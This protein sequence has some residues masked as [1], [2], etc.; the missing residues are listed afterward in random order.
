M[1]ISDILSG[2][3]KWCVNRYRKGCGL[4]FYRFPTDPERR[5]RWVAA[6]AR[7]NWTPNEYSRLCSAHFVTGTKSDDPLSPD[8]VPTLFSHVE[9][10]IKRKAERDLMSMLC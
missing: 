10:P 2:K 3:N 1:T 4:S 7:K 9:S 5:T 6:V 8:F